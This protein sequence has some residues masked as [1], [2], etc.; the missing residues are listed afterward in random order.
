MS[1]NSTPTSE[2][3]HIGFFGR[4][5]AG[6]SSLV[7]AVTGQNLS[8]VSNTKGTTTDPVMKSME[9]LPLGAV[10]IIDTAGLDDEGELGSLRIEKTKQILRKVDIAILVID[11]T[12]GIQKEDKDLIYDF[13][14]NKTKYIIVYNKS[15][16][17]KQTILAKENEIYTSA[18]NNNNIY[19]LKELIASIYKK[20][21]KEITLVKDIVNANDNVI[22]VTPIDSSAP[23]GRLIL[24][25]QQ[26]T[27][28][29]L[30]IGA[31]TTIIKETE[32]TNA[33]NSLTNKP[34][35]VITDSQVFGKVNKELS[36]GILL[37][38]FSILFARY[39]GVL[40]FAVQGVT[41]LETLKNNDTILISEGCTHHRQCNDIGSVKLPNWIK[42]YTKKNLN[43]EYSSGNS[44]PTDLSKYAMI[45]HCGGCMLNDKEV[46]YRYNSATK[47]NI[48][49]T[50][51]GITIAYINKILKRSIEIFP[52]L[53]TII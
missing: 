32:L 35:L 45:V 19:E 14:K 21:V 28:E 41:K 18:I 39:K 42:E 9:L 3:I 22:L 27:R 37:T 34:K 50:N 29:L 11:A 33:I 36:N 20:E 10:T 40:D 4:R 23:K 53:Y 6:K 51:Y 38:S 44:F 30:E 48:P 2:R 16:L 1:L 25:Q 31:I 47:Q 12:E 7:N 17:L 5:N 24:P 43:F 52:N 49:I 46:L 13:E 8:I 26:V 15:D